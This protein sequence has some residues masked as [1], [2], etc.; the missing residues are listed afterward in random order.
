MLQCLNTLCAG[1]VTNKQSC[2][3]V[4]IRLQKSRNSSCISASPKQKALGGFE[5]TDAE[6]PSD[7]AATSF[8]RDGSVWAETNENR[9]FTPR[10]IREESARAEHYSCSGQSSSAAAAAGT[11]PPPTFCNFPLTALSSRHVALRQRR[12]SFVFQLGV[13]TPRLFSGSSGSPCDCEQRMNSDNSDADCQPH[14][15]S[16]E[17]FC[18]ERFFSY[19]DRIQAEPQ[20]NVL[21]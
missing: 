14:P 19:A 9:C 5:V 6:S 16:R 17:G 13:T 11:P 4:K 1:S 10:P 15:P 2:L 12:S 8:V 18:L 3:V 20:I 21:S 7:S